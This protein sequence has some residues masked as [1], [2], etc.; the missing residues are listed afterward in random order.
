MEEPR[1]HALDYVSVYR[2][3]K[4]WL[5]TPIALSFVVGLALVRLLP[6]EYRSSATLGVTAPSVSPTLVNQAPPLDNEERM[7]AIT[8]Q[9]LSPQILARVAKEEGLTTSMS[10]DAAV[11]HLRRKTEVSVPEPVAQTGEP[12]RV[13]TVVISYLDPEPD[14]A[15]RV[16]NRVATVFVDEH[17]KSREARAEDTSAFLAQQL[18]ASEARLADLESRLRRAKE[19]HMGQLPEQTGANLAT[20]SGLRQQLEANSTALRGEQDRLS[21]I[22]GQLDAL[23]K[24]SS[25]VLIVPRVGGSPAEVAQAPE[26]RVMLL[27]RMLAEAR[28]VYTDKHPEVVHLEEEIADA[29]RDAA[30]EKARPAEDR[31]AQMMLDP[32]YRQLMVDREAARLRIRDL[33][34]AEADARRQ[35]G[36]YQAR[37]EQAPMVEQQLTSVQRDYELEKVQY[38]DLSA[39]RHTATI[40]ENVERN[41]R[42]EQFTVLYAASWPNDPV[43]PIPLRVMLMSI[44]I[45]ICLG[46]VLTLGR[47][48]LDRSVHDV[49]DLKDEFEL[50]V[51]GEV[52]RIPT[53]V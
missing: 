3:R 25:S 16:T 45:G 19:A 48:Y 17:S 22:E 32:A 43:K 41:R 47:E 9:L 28:T 10:V 7:R 1:V 4:W 13:E 39:K 53:T 52:A 30:A 33:Q 44:L 51:L 35:I 2:R 26:T 50:P 5:L 42:G 6:K 29:R 20:L 23:K 46:G 14:R 34:R 11:N 37:V 31:A 38:S 40:A 27:Q 12:R 36:M 24:G 18:H 15:Q 49:R 21:M 8:Q